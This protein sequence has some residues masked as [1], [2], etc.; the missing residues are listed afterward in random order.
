M[1]KECCEI[2]LQGED[3]FSEERLE[4]FYEAIV[5][6]SS[7]QGHSISERSIQK[8]RKTIKAFER[9][10]NFYLNFGF[11]ALLFVPVD[12]IRLV[13]PDIASRG[14]NRRFCATT[15]RRLGWV[16]RNVRV[17]DMIVIFYG[18]KVPY[19]IR[20]REV[21][22]DE[23]YTFISECYIRGLMQGDAFESNIDDPVF[24]LK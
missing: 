17:G 13:G 14:N 10:M 21:G 7:Y 12:A 9:F 5:F 6:E 1:T 2:A 3:E 8:Q 19:V 4:E 18:A 16:P 11:M 15:N 24:E 22:K 23:G 20:P